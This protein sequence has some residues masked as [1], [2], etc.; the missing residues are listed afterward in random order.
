MP[1]FGELVK[2]VL[3][4]TSLWTDSTHWNRHLQGMIGCDLAV[5]F[6]ETLALIQYGHV[7]LA[8][9]SEITVRTIAARLTVS[10]NV[11]LFEVSA[12]LDN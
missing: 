3:Q 9:L 12:F 2:Q 11:S 8:P 5:R 7:F 6:R 10:A 4:G 1:N